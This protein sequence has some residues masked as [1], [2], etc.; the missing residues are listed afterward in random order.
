MLLAASLIIRTLRYLIKLEPLSTAATPVLQYSPTS[1]F[2]N[3]QEKLIHSKIF[4]IIF[5][6]LKYLIV[7]RASSP[8]PAL[9]SAARALSPPLAG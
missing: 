4:S 5:I 8:E 7:T 3:V 9:V 2:R 1:P 6:F